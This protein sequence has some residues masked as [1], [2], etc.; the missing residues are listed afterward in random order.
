LIS[1]VNLRVS[2]TNPLSVTTGY[3][4]AANRD[5][6]SHGFSVGVNVAF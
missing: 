2:I 4:I 3:N 6:V 5:Y 1:G